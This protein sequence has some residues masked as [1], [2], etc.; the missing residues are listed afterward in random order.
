MKRRNFLTAL[1]LAPIVPA[2]AKLAAIEGPTVLASTA[3]Q[4]FSRATNFGALSPTQMKV[5]SR[6]LWNEARESSFTT[7]MLR[8]GVL[9]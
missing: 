6:D 9:G 3:N 1:A 2:A 7:N 8:D 4:G 5:W